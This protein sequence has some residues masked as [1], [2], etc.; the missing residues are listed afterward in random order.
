MDK[1]ITK[2]I[3]K[4]KNFSLKSQGES[5]LPILRENDIIYFKKISFSKIKVNDLIIF[6]NQKKN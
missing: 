6:K 4:T 2:I 3:S 5:M 1:L